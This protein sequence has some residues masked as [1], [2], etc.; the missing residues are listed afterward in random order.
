VKS[1][2]RR[3]LKMVPLSHNIT[4]SFQVSLSLH[5]GTPL[6]HTT[7]GD[8]PR[9]WQRQQRS[10]EVRRTHVSDT[11]RSIKILHRVCVCVCVCVCLCVCVCVYTS[12]LFPCCFNSL[13]D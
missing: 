1:L 2:A 12:K 11:P 7:N 3:Q 6:N 5:A 4:C 8:F 10:G 13:D 9:R